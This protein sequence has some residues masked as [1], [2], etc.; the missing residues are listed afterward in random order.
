MSNYHEK[1][2]ALVEAVVDDIRASGPETNRAM[3]YALDALQA[4]GKCGDCDYWKNR[5]WDLTNS[6]KT[7]KHCPECGRPFDSEPGRVEPIVLGRATLAPTAGHPLAVGGK[8]RCVSTDKY[9]S[10][11]GGNDDAEKYLKIGNVYTVEQTVEHSWHTKVYLKELPGKKFNSVQFERVD[12]ATPLRIEPLPPIE[13]DIDVNGLSMAFHRAVR[14]KTNEV[15]AAINEG[16]T[17]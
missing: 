14:D 3:K 16:R 4:A 15:I 10:N 13:D 17:G 8:V 1:M 5:I 9:Q 12:S 11:W 7:G 6:Y 2:K